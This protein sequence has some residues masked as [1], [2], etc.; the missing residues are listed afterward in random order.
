[1]IWQVINKNF[2]SFQVKTTTVDFCRNEYN[3]TGQCNKASCPLANSNY[4]T[5]IE[6]E[7]LCYLYIKTVERAHTPKKLWEK[8]KL[9]TN[10]ETALA[11]I[12]KHMKNVYPEYLI[13]RCK[14]RLLRLRQTL[15]RMRRLQMNPKKKLVSVKSKTERRDSAREKWA[16]QAAKLD[17][18]IEDQ[19][20]QR[21]RQGIY[22]D[23]YNLNPVAVPLPE[24]EES[25]TEML[26]EAEARGEVEF[27]EDDD[28]LSS[29]SEDGDV[30][31]FIPEIMQRLR[32]RGRVGGPLASSAREKRG[33][34]VEIE[35]ERDDEMDTETQ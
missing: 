32:P 34:R 19:L 16:E 4:G 8:I 29:E 13:N 15:I 1:M 31:E 27:V 14:Q 22:G 20:L 9:S 25:D 33:A 10:F 6:Q 24:E 17:N 18:A 30:T 5:V 26:A 28:A 3:V 2:C 35:Y 23:T 21:L 12:D 11:E 7:G